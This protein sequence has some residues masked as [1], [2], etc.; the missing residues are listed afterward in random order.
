MP[1]GNSARLLAQ[2]GLPGVAARGRARASARLSCRRAL[3]GRDAA[4]LVEVLE[5]VQAH[6]ID[7]RQALAILL[8]GPR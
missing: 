8:G 6:R 3:R 4:R 2:S 1:R 5:A 7:A